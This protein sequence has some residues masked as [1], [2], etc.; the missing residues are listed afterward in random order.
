MRKA[1]SVILVIAL[2]F[3]IV[4][5][6]NNI[7]IPDPGSE[8]GSG[9]GLAPAE[10]ALNDMAMIRFLGYAIDEMNYYDADDSS[11]D[12]T[13][14]IEDL[15]E[16]DVLTYIAIAS[17]GAFN[18]IWS[19]PYFIGEDGIKYYYDED[20]NE[21]ISGAVRTDD[22]S[23]SFSVIDDD[24]R[25]V[26]ETSGMKF[27][28]DF[29]SPEVETLSVDLSAKITTTETE[30][31]MVIKLNGIEYPALSII[32]ESDG[33][34]FTYG[35]YSYKHVHTFDDWY[36]SHLP[37][38]TEPGRKYRECTVCHF[39]G[40]AEVPP[41]NIRRIEL[42]TDPTKNYDGKP[43]TISLDDIDFLGK[44][45]A[46]PKIEY[47]LS[48]ESDEEYKTEAPVNVGT[49]YIRITVP[50]GD[51]YAYDSYI[52]SNFFEINPFDISIL[53]DLFS[54]KTYNGE[55]QKWT[56]ILS[57]DDSGSDYY[58]DGMPEGEKIRITVE[59]D[60]AD[61]GSYLFNLNNRANP[62]SD[63]DMTVEYLDGTSEANYSI[64]I[65][66]A[67][68]E[69]RPAVLSG[70][71]HAEKEYDGSSIFCVSGTEG[72]SGI[73]E[74]DLEGLRFEIFRKTQYC[75]DSDEIV[76]VKIYQNDTEITKNY[77][78]NKDQFTVRLNPRKLTFTEF[79]EILYTPLLENNIQIVKDRAIRL[80][81][82]NNAVS[83]LVAELDITKSESDWNVADEI[84]LGDIS[85]CLKNNNYSIDSKS[86]PEKIRVVSVD[87]DISV[88]SVPFSISAGEYKYC[89]FRLGVNENAVIRIDGNDNDKV[90]AYICDS[91]GTH[92][93]V[94][95]V[96]KIV[97][98]GEEGSLTLGP[99]AGTFYLFIY[100]MNGADGLTITRT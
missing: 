29:T 52:D 85:N 18:G 66:N 97:I 93:Y 43:V 34:L 48:E 35:E 90:L 31:E 17:H 87:H 40:E 22:T 77:S 73:A 24:V 3:S 74:S 95:D 53:N 44:G 20:E 45:T 75:N 12:T 14:T 19:E 83:S 94:D 26:T 56:V 71:L 78:Y 41:K 42:K 99:A 51:G 28:I 84:I 10:K 81:S 13:Y 37:S 50:A 58:I 68:A 59:T 23:F 76:N 4:S 36:V 49:Y 60:N 69:I 9:S 25:Y 79:G 5:C 64:W 39:E 11:D 21:I 92:Y 54:P 80:G 86:T 67:K 6:K 15:F 88:L 27:D 91:S 62:Y 1:I 57:G 30:Q 100:S 70:S 98:N 33:Y 63:G 7:S 82:R 61:A 32:T 2:V 55:K 96:R 8:S 16:N 46:Q 65:P 89:S 47:R 38:D 72:I